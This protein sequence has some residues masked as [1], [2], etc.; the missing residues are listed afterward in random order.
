MNSSSV[1]KVGDAEFDRGEEEREEED[2]I[3]GTRRS[4]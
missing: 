3:I 1:T 2:G 4:L